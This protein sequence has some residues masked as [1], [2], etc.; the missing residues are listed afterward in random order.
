[1]LACMLVDDMEA[2]VKMGIVYTM[3]A[4]CSAMREWLENN[5]EE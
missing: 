1:M 5:K 2:L 3:P 4:S